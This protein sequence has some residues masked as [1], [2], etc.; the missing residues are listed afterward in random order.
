MSAA[1]TTT[2]RRLAVAGV[3]TAVVVGVAWTQRRDLEDVVRGV[4]LADPRW[5][6]VLAAALLGWWVAWTALHATALAG[7]TRVRAGDLPAVAGGAVSAVALNS[8]VTSAGLAGLAAMAR[9]GRRRGLPRT[10]VATA[11][12]LAATVT[13]PGFLL[14]LLAGF[15][16]LGARGELTGLDWLAGGVFTLLT[17]A[18]VA[19]TVLAVRRPAALHALAVRAARVRAAVTR[20]PARDPDPARTRELVETAEVLTRRPARAVPPLLAAAC[21][22]VAGV[23]MLWA[24]LAVVGGPH[25]L[26]LALSA[27]V[28]ASVAAIL[29][30]LPGGIGAAELGAGAALTVGG[31]PLGVAAAATLLFRV[32]EFWVP[33]AVGG[34]AWVGLR[35]GEPA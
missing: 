25:D 18:R 27:Y 34:L 31:V 10:D 35:G 21:V 23:L 11:Y 14:V 7:V 28:L 26:G 8:V 13:D 5:L 20:R 1:G 30:P 16:V 22:D 4:H 33:L 3:V 24:A 6:L 15:G 17:V 9:A 19:L 29:G 12:L 2:G 32:A